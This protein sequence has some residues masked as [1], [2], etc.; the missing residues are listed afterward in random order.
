MPKVAHDFSKEIIFYIIKC[1]N[2]AKKEIYVGSTFN[3]VKRKTQHKSNSTNPNSRGYHFKQYVYIRE[4]GGWDNFNMT[5]IDR[6]VCVDMLEVRKHEQTLIT[7]YKASLN[8][9]KAFGA[10]TLSEY[11]HQHYIENFEKIKSEIINIILK[12]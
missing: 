5:M 10:E 6:K 7:Q 12:I 8:T 1:M 4:N 3:F 9:N 11:K 2:L